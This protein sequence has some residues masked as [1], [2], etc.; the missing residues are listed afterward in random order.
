M[1]LGKRLAH[2][3]EI[4]YNCAML[5]VNGTLATMDHQNRV[6]PDGALLIEGDQKEAMVRGDRPSQPELKVDQS[7]LH[8]AQQWVRSGHHRH[9]CGR[10]GQCD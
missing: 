10:D 4:C 6:I 8:L 1:L 7:V 9:R 3:D 2:G 5:I